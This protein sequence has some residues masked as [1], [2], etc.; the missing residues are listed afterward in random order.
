MASFEDFSPEVNQAV[1]GLAWL[2]HLEASTSRWGHTWTFRT[3]KADEEL[4]AALVAKDYQDTFGQVKAHAWAHVAASLTTVDGE[5]NWCPPIGPDRAQHLRAKFTYCTQNWY[6]PVGEYLFSEYIDLI[7]K[8]A[9]ALE[10]VDS[11]SSR[12]LRTSFGTQDSS[13]TQEDSPVPTSTGSTSDS[14]PISSD[15]MKT[16]ADSPE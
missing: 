4:I 15:V 10:A 14:S 8:Q 1:D 16:L 2:G 6:W 9:E 5:E 13:E 11:L 7:N 12:S 3:L